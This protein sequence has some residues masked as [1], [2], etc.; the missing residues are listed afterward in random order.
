MKRIVKNPAHSQTFNSWAS[1]QGFPNWEQFS[2]TGAYHQLRNHILFNEQKGISGY[3][4]E[5]L[6]NPKLIPHIDHYR[7]KG[8]YPRLTFDYENFVVDY[9]H[10][11]YGSSHKDKVVDGRFNYNGIFDPVHEDMSEYIQFGPHGEMLPE[12]NLEPS[13]DSKVR[14]TIEVFDLNNPALK[15]RRYVVMCTLEAYK[16]LEREI[17]EECMLASGFPSVILWWFRSRGR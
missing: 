7:K 11:T 13:V 16:D 3:T 10:T 14:N 12:F 1:R 17:V 2:G 6:D 9:H 8:I 5:P 15:E 4:E